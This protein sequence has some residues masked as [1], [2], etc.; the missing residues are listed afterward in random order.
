M[1]LNRRDC[2]RAGAAAGAGAALSGCSLVARRFTHP[3]APKSITLPEGPVDP[4]V[5][6]V[7]RVSYGPTPGEITRVVKMGAEAYVSQ[8]LNPDDDEPSILSTRIGGLEAFQLQ[9]AELFDLPREELIRQI[10]QHAIL[11]SIYSPHQLRERMVEFWSNHFN[12]YARKGDGAWYLPADG[13]QV[14]R[15][16]ALGNFP[17]LLRAS[18]HSPA[19]LQYLDNQ[20]NRKMDQKGGGANENYARE[21]MELHTLGVHGGYTQKDVQEVARCLTGWA[22]EDRS[23]GERLFAADRKLPG[24]FRFDPKRHDEGVKTVLGQRIGPNGGVQD[25]E[26]V[27]DILASHPSTAKFISQKICRYFLGDAAD[28]WTPKVADIYLKTNGDV[29]A[30]LRPILLS[31]ELRTG[32]AILKRPYDY[33]V[34]ALR[35]LNADTDGGK[36]LQAQLAGMGQPLFQWPMPDGY[37]DRTAAWTGSLLHRWNFALALVEGQVGGTSVDFEGLA[38]A[39][40][41]NGSMPHAAVKLVLSRK[42]DELRSLAEAM[43]KHGGNVTS[44]KSTNEP[45]LLAGCAALAMASPEFQWR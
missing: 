27:L 20:V 28:A 32:P 38:K 25:G 39:V 24:S 43:A 12:I 36:G 22:L 4:I 37:P 9:T 41:K 21:L 5:R 3:E 26:Q 19:M 1:K 34:S 8:Q 40:E 15:K 2:L 33:A 31:E 16:N 29:K 17:D 14:I 10:Q 11:H 44:A 18:A 6:L 23:L 7:N 42:P 13:V 30:M 45:S 35:A